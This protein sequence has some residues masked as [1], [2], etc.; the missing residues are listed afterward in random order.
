RAVFAGCGASEQTSDET[1]TN[2]ETTMNWY[3][4]Q[5]QSAQLNPFQTNPLQW[6]AQIGQGHGHG[7]NPWAGQH[8]PGQAAYGQPLGQ[9]GSQ[10]FGQPSFGGQGQGW[11][12][13]R[14]LSQQDVGDV[15]RQLVPLL[16]QILAQSQTAPSA[17]GYGGYGQ[18][19]QYGQQPYGQFGRQLTQQ[20]VNEVV[21]QILPIVPQIVGA[22]QT[23]GPLPAAAVFGAHAGQTGG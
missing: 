4:M 16:P 22:L 15:V 12:Q 17:F 3:D 7:Y 5:Q 18:Q 14:Q 21:R 23:Q 1:A 13:Q 2:R 20:D 6:A 8:G 19:S 9:Y 11:G 10:P